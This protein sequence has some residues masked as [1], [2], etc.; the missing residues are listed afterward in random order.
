MSLK[1]EQAQAG[2]TAR[3]PDGAKAGR[4]ALVIGGGIA[5]V[6]VADHVSRGGLTVHL[7]EKRPDIGGH[8]AEM[9]CKADTACVRCNVCVAD[10]LFRTVRERAARR[11]SRARGMPAPIRLHTSCEALD[12]RP[13]QNGSRF[14]AVLGGQGARAKRVAADFL[15]VA[16]GHRPFDPA[17]NSSYGYGAIPNVITGVEAERQLADR[18]EI[19]RPSDGAVPRRMA[20]IQ[21]VGS[22]T[23]EIHR[24]PEDTDYCS[25]VCCAYALRMARRVKHRSPE[26][27][28]AVFHM[29]IQNFGKGFETF[30]GR[31][32][33]AMRFVRSRPYELKAGPDGTVRVKVATEPDAGGDKSDG[34]AQ[35]ATREETFDLVVLSVG[36]RPPSDGA[37]LADML[38]MAVDE[39]GFP[40]LKGATAQPELQRQ[41]LYVA[42]TAESPK[43]IA[44]CLA[45]AE[46]VAALILADAERRTGKAPRGVLRD[47]AVVGG[48]VAGM[49]TALALA[50]LGHRVA[51]IHRGTDL[52]AGAEPEQAGHLGAD[53]AEA[54]ARARDTLARLAEA[55]ANEPAIERYPETDMESVTGELGGFS[56]TLRRNGRR[57]TVAAGA[58]ALATGS[59][60]RSAA[61]SLSGAVVD[62]AGLAARMRDGAHGGSVAFLMDMDGEHGR[63]AWIRALSM[64]EQLALRGMRTKIFCGNVRVAATGIERLYRRARATGTAVVKFD[65]K[66][67]VS[68][69]AGR[70][71]VRSKDAVTGA[72]LT[73]TFDLAVFVEQQDWRGSAAL[74]QGV[75]GLRAG[76]DGELQADNVWLLP[77][78]TNRPGIFTVGSARGDSECRAALTDALAVAHSMHALLSGDEMRK[79]DD[80]AQVDAE[81]C[82]LCLTCLRVCPHGAIGIDGERKAAF[83]SPISCQRCGLCIGEC[84]AQAITL[85]G[86][87]DEQV[88]RETGAKAE[89]VVFACENS[90]VPAMTG[91]PCG[92]S[93]KIIEVPCAGQVDPRMALAALEAGAA[94]VVIAGCHPG[95]CQYLSGA[96]RAEQRMKQLADLLEKAGYD[97][98]RV[99]FHGMAG[100][101]R[102]EWLNG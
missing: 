14:T 83:P 11:S 96:G 76:P 30:Y 33:D 88:A 57:Q 95:S 43:D 73:E 19:V 75:A 29:D 20:F 90:A 80:V 78:R 49:R 87:S 102:Q 1:Q 74:R 58:L 35:A 12:I 34:P 42:G 86:V 24:R 8:A 56:L 37:R 101:E 40:G 60:W 50:R 99:S 32:K 39:Q 85:P 77:G 100:V 79:R 82:V 67:V 51:L 64:A 93:I 48:G 65:K 3:K 91:R 44:G 15:V 63:A 17:E 41:G 10:E 55:V 36:I 59:T 45:Q 52:G 38:G 81:K 46:S 47:T 71:V 21:C 54:E 9:G 94:K 98:S 6:A 70:A 31:C 4:T 26:T 22:R 27:D 66:P 97:G 89:T 61:E 2:A 84:P 5:G 18:Q 16:I 62:L 7:V 25:T 23:E 92:E 69:Q 53:A 28:I 68:E 13:G 72:N